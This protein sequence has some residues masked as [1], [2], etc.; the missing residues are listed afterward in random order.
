[1]QNTRKIQIRQV[2]AFTSEATFGAH[3]VLIDRPVEKGGTDHGPMGG[4]LFLAAV[5]GCFTS[6]LLAAIRTR[7]AEIS[8]VRLE[9]VGILADSPARYSGV[10]L[11][12]AADGDQE[13]LEHLVE[14]ADRGCIMMNT[15]R[16]TLDLKIRIGAPV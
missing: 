8:G 14:L 2:S 10:E 3:R 1:M 7:G 6:N 13:L 12:V 11:H 4:D 9:V 16:D 5:G 15:L